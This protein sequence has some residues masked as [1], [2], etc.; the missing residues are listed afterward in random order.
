MGNRL[1][2]NS[3]TGMIALDLGDGT[4]VSGEVRVRGNLVTFLPEGELA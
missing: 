4:G 3:E 2:H 1:F